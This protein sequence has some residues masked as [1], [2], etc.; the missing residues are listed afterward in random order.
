MSKHFLTAAPPSR[1]RQGTT[2]LVG[3]GL[4]G[5]TAAALLAESGVNCLLLEKEKTVG[6][7]SRSHVLDDIV[8]DMGPHIFLRSAQ[9]AEAFMMELLKGERVFK[10][11]FRCAISSKGGLWKFPAGLF[12]V[13]RYPWLYK[14]QMLAGLLKK[15]SPQP[16]AAGG[17]AVSVEEELADK[18][19]PAFYA[20]VFEKMLV[21][22]TFLTGDK[23]HLDWIAR[24]D[25]NVR[26]RKEPF[27]PLSRTGILRKFLD[28]FYQVYYYPQNGFQVFADKLHARFTRAGGETLLDCGPLHF[29]ADQGRIAS[30]TVRG[31]D[32]PVEHVVW[33]GSVN[34]LNRA[35]GSK[36][37]EIRYVKTIL[38]FL[39]Y[40]REKPVERPYVYVYYPQAGLI[41]NRVYYPSSIYR[42][43]SPPG[44]EG[45]CLELNYFDELDQVDDKELVRRT[46]EDVAK[47]G[48]FRPGELRCSHVLRLGESIP[49]YE[50]DYEAKM[51]EAYRDIHSFENLYSVG[52]QGGYYFCLSAAA[53]RQGMKTADHILNSGPAGAR[54]TP[55]GAGGKARL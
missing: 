51:S 44:K 50:L 55:P 9:P 13:L 46:V 45:I 49:L 34:G 19:G 41:F 3:S 22:K 54:E 6:G 32:Y 53:V 23:L 18:I 17:K 16:P 2:V 29:S 43:C 37:A 12:D 4:A 5:L 39:T 28:V 11:R 20:D 14:K 10:R 33:T 8:F 24:V 42:E 30:V 38:V 27:A 35:L 52:R 48:W 36:A 15:K 7:A 25:R 21:A 47:A 40:N 26:N 1:P 31:A